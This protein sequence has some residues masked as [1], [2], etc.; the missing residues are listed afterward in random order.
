MASNPFV[1]SWPGGKVLEV[2]Y[3]DSLADG[4]TGLIPQSLL[5]LAKKRVT[6]FVDVEERDIARAI[7]FLHS[8]HHQVVEGSGAV[9]VAAM[10][11]GRV[12]VKGLRVGV[13]I[14]GGNIDHPR[15]MEILEEYSR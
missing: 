10:A 15:L 9:G 5:D 6:G 4:L 3:Q 11:S 7:A 14:S 2:E 12:A 13:V 8:S 1:V